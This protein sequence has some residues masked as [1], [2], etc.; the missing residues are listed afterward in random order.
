MKGKR[1]TN[2]ARVVELA[3]KNKSIW[4]D[5]WGRQCSAAWLQNMPT[6]TIVGYIRMGWLFEYHPKRK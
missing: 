1:I 5:R 3:K 4:H 6:H 2:C